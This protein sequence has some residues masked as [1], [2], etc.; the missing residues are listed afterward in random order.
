[1][2]LLELEDVHVEYGRSSRP[3][4]AGV[5]LNVPAGSAVGIVGESGSGKTTLAR[6]LM[7]LVR[8]TR[9]RVRVGGAD[10]MALVRPARRRLR[11]DGMGARERLARARVVQM[12]FQD[13]GSS[14]NPSLTV[15]QTLRELIT[16]HRLR[17]GADVR[18]RCAEL[19]SMVSLPERFLGARPQEMSGGQRQRAA[20]ARALAV[21]PAALIADEAV[22][23]LDVSVQAGI[24]N[25]LADLRERLELTL[26]FISHDIAT[27]RQVCDEVAVMY[28]GRIVE[29]GPVDEVLDSPRDPYTQALI[30]AVPRLDDVLLA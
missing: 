3:A 2:S 5:S 16:V 15:E 23:A 12:V 18:A 1:M 11:V 19:L 8:P 22:A 30:A 20:I 27:V 13:P 7:R 25:L 26:I 24:L 21:E 14:L 17:R 9:G 4:L 10:P 6:V 29:H 28:L